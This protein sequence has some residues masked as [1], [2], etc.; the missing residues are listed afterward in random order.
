MAEHLVRQSLD[1]VHTRIVRRPALDA[2]YRRALGVGK[3]C[4]A[5]YMGW[6]QRRGPPAC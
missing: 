2:G 1:R 3:A 6:A 5:P 4:R